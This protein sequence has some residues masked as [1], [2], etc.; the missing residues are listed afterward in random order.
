MA[1]NNDD[2]VS[3]RE[4]SFLDRLVPQV[5][6]HLAEHAAEDFDADA[7]QRRFHAWLAEHTEENSP[8]R[9][10]HFDDLHDIDDRRP[11]RPPSAR[12]MLPACE[13]GSAWDEESPVSVVPLLPRRPGLAG[14]E[15]TGSGPSPGRHLTAAAPS[16]EIRVGM[17][18][19]P[20]SGKTTYL[21]ALRH[22]LDV[23]PANGRWNVHP[24]NDASADLMVRLTQDLVDK[25]EFPPAT[26]LGEETELRWHFAGDLAGSQFDRRILR[27]RGTLPSKFTLNLVD[28]SGE[29][30]GSAPQ[31]KNVPLHVINSALGYLAGAQGL[32]YFF[33]PIAERERGGSLEYLNRV[34]IDL[35]RRMLAEDRLVNGYL[36]QYVSVCITKFDHPELFR[37]AQRLGLVSFGEDGRPQVL[38]KDAETLFNMI[39]DGSFWSDHETTSTASFIR[40]ELRKRFHPGRIRY[41]ATSAIGFSQPSGHDPAA[42]L[43]RRSRFNPEDH[44]NFYETERGMRI[45][46]PIA[47]IN[48]LEPL[49]SLHQQIWGVG[50]TAVTRY[51]Q[52]SSPSSAEV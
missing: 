35:S 52:L 23:D 26:Q 12:A 50:K 13:K 10:P 19:A 2:A 41:F 20:A 32:L 38:G 8:P 15:P 47:P 24:A 28:V 30:F 21:G 51:T 6:D 9:S 29:A 37:R 11:R 36:P 7:S 42:G 17:W 49:L 48:V 22:A 39:C 27:R 34:I 25:H 5:A 46:G 40:Y 44:V 31:G 1:E 18:G 33:D 3:N 14:R 43:Q 16:G 45:K 4:D